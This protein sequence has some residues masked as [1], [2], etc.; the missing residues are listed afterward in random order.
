M[1]YRTSIIFQFNLKARLK[2]KIPD[3]MNFN[4]DNTLQVEGSLKRILYILGFFLGISLSSLP[5][6]IRIKQFSR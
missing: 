2:T 4:R 6:M 5:R 1:W 3:F